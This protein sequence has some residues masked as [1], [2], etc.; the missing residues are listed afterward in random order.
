[1]GR[2]LKASF[3]PFSARVEIAQIYLAARMAKSCPCQKALEC[4]FEFA[5]F[6]EAAALR[7]ECH[8]SEIRFG[9]GRARL[10][11]II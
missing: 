10:V 7:S 4:L 3:D 6:L 8:V 9:V 1:M 2:F 11:T 5:L